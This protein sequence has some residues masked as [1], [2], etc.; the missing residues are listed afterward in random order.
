MNV[1]FHNL[2]ML[3]SMVIVQQYS[4]MDRQ[5]QEKHIQW[6]EKIKYLR[7]K[8]ISKMKEKVLSLEQ[9]NNYG[10]KLNKEKII[11]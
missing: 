8:F 1:M 2:L 4:P 9:Y 5:A 10:K 7:D 6:Q 11:I 3:R